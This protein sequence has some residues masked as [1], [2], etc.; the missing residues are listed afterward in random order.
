MWAGMLVLGPM[1]RAALAAAGLAYSHRRY[2]ELA[3]LEMCGAMFI[4]V[5]VLVPLWLDAIPT[6][7]P[8][9]LLHVVML[10]LMLVVML[11]RRS[12]GT[13][14]ARH[15]CLLQVLKAL[16]GFLPPVAVAAAGTA[17]SSANLFHP[18]GGTA[19]PSPADSSGRRPKIDRGNVATGA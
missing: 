18:P 12:Q 9:M 2:L 8:F 13:S 3:P 17:R 14:R 11:W 7:S 1:V 16:L 19:A 4:P 15:E 10:P 5:I 6:R